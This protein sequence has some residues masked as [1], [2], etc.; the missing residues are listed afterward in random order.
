MKWTQGR[1][2]EASDILK[3]PDDLQREVLKRKIN[4]NE[5]RESLKIELRTTRHL[6][7]MQSLHRWSF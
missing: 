2:E 1:G 6:Q 4:T 5:V 3:W 7:G